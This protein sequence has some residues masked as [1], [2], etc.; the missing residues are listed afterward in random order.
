MDL[1]NFE[2]EA[3]AATLGQMARGE[4]H[5]PDFEA[6]RLWRGMAV[7]C[8]LDVGANRGQSLAS[9]NAIFPTSTIHCFEANPVFFN[10]LDRVVDAREGRSIVHHHGLGTSNVTLP[11]YVP[12]GAGRPFLEESSMVREYYDKPWVAEKFRERGG[13]QLEQLSVAIRRGDDF[14]LVPQIVKI[15]VEGAEYDVIV[16]LTQTIRRSCPIL[17]VENSDWHRVT[18]AL[19]ELGYKPYR[20]N[21]GERRLV[22]FHGTTTNT[23]YL[24]SNQID[25]F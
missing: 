5:D 19:G 23:F 24:H 21:P 2:E 1:R 12:W 4:L 16:G 20:Y 6:L 15:D 22:P 8:I 13:L 14:G 10:I 18:E 7:E 17:L 9:L 25:L 11:L 3:I